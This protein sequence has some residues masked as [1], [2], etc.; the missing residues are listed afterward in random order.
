MNEFKHNINEQVMKLLNINLSEAD[1]FISPIHKELF[2]REI[3]MDIFSNEGHCLKLA[4]FLGEKYDVSIRHRVSNGLSVWY[5]DTDNDRGSMKS[6]Y[7]DA[8]ADYLIRIN[9]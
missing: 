7:E 5:W 1:E 3:R 4:K 2:L 8:C 9:G 6:T